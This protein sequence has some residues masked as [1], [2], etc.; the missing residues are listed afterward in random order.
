MGNEVNFAFLVF[1][2][3]GALGDGMQVAFSRWD[4]WRL[5]SSCSAQ[6]S[7]CNGFSCYGAQALGS[8]GLSSCG[9]GA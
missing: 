6:A 7:H 5:L 1:A 2:G 4:E 3:P 9:T 8:R